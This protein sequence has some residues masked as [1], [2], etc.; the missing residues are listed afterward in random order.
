M[1]SRQVALTDRKNGVGHDRQEQAQSGTR[2]TRG[3]NEAPTSARCEV[4]DGEQHLMLV[5][6]EGLPMR[7]VVHS[8]AIQDREGAVLALAGGFRGPQ[9][10]R[11]AS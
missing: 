11:L 10:Q 2:R 3:V 8:A 6:S 4:W 9:L 1:G 7:G 5:D